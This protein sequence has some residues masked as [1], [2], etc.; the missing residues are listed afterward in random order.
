MK[1]LRHFLALLLALALPAPAAKVVTIGDSLT[2]EYDVIPDIPG[3]DDLPTDYAKV[4]IGAAWH[5]A[6]GR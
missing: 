2:A 5:S 6:T 1:T 4:G 3:F